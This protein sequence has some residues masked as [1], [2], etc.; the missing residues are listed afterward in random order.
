MQTNLPGG[1]SAYS[2]TI[3]AE[4]KQ[5]YSEAMNGLVGVSYE[6]L[7]VSTQVVAGINYQ[8]FCNA[9]AVYPNAPISAALITINKPLQGSA[10]IVSISKV[11]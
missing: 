6:P 5:A 7:A 11:G 2:T 9:Q 1:W 10:H 8:F 3:S 4:A